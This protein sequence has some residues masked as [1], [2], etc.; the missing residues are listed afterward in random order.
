MFEMLLGCFLHRICMWKRSKT[1]TIDEIQTFGD[2]QHWG[3]LLLPAVR[4]EHSLNQSHPELYSFL[5]GYASTY[6]YQSV[7]AFETL[8][9]M[10]MGNNVLY[11]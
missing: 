5:L 3:K 6:S 10:G 4:V 11:K 8:K 7:Y 9:K 2:F 1:L